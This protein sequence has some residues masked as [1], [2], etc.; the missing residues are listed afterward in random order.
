MSLAMARKTKEDAQ[1]TRDQ[2]MDAA[3]TVFYSKGFTLTTMSDIAESAAL[4]RGAVYGH[5]KSKLELATAMAERVIEQVAPFHGDENLSPLLNLKHYCLQEI[6]SYIEPS[7]IQKVLFFLYVGIDDS[8]E[9]L[10]HRYAWEKKRITQINALLKQAI[11]VGELKPDADFELMSLYCQS[12]IEGVF[13]IV[14]FGNLPETQRWHKAEQLCEY[15][16]QRLST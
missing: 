6:R 14:H 11:T 9:L 10:Q 5:Y 3:E 12:I 16:L 7:S 2:I 4:S 1:K 13:S 15:G 8:P